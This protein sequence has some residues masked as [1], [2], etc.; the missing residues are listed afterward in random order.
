LNI[1]SDSKFPLL[2]SFP[3]PWIRTDEWYNF[4]EIPDHVN[5]LVSIDESSYEGGENGEQH[6]MVWYHEYDGGR[7]F[8]L[9]LGHS[10]E[11]FEE[12]LFLD[13]LYSGLEYAIGD[14][15]ELNYAKT[16]SEFPPDANRFSK[17][18]FVR[19]LDEPTEMTILPDLS[20]LITERKGGLQY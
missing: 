20:I 10:S 3:E 6:P 1:H 15:K 14:N 8:Y 17:I 16:K 9:G 19:G 2:D 7:A 12:P 13:L 18:E 4:R 5:V 11:S